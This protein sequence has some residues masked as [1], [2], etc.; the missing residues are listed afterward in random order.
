VPWTTFG[1]DHTIKALQHAIAHHH[2]N[3]AYLLTGPAHIGKTTLAEDL[4]RAI[5]CETMQPPCDSC[6]SCQLAAAGTHPDLLILNNESARDNVA[7]SAIWDPRATEEAPRALDI[8]R[9]RE[10]ARRIAEFPI[11]ALHRVVLIDG[12]LISSPAASALL[13]IIEEPPS[14]TVFIL[15]ARGRETLPH[16]IISR[17]QHLPLHTVPL[18]QL[19]AWISSR[20]CCSPELATAA[21]WFAGGRAGLALRIAKAEHHAKALQERSR[22]ILSLPF[23]QPLERLQ[24]AAD[25]GKNVTSARAVL[26]LSLQLWRALLRYTAI[27]EDRRQ[28][29]QFL[30]RNIREAYRQLSHAVLIQH[31]QALKIASAALDSNVQPQLTLE[32]LFARLARTSRSG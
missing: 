8:E 21:A 29:D 1:Q 5:L 7:L 20:H 32:W 16:P 6:R 25:W 11:R 31:V 10:I 15:R 19:S 22:Q 18:I 13:K 23:I 14:Q 9:V 3:H 28:L 26:D 4:A 30:P 2:I 24:F 17:C 12:S 27:E